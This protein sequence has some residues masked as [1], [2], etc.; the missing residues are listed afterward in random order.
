V[1]K[2]GGWGLG[3]QLCRAPALGPDNKGLGLNFRAGEKKPWGQNGRVS[4]HMK[5]RIIWG[6]GG[7]ADVGA[8]EALFGEIHSL[9]GLVRRQT[10]WARSSSPGK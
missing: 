5:A 1:K 3:L 9:F 8:F 4:L 10:G 6:P 7:W 2:W